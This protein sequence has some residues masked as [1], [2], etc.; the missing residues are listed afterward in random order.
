[1]PIAE[2]SLIVA[3]ISATIAFI[4]VIV[5]P[6]IS[7]KISKRQLIFPIRQKW[8]EDLR[9]VMSE[10]LSE[11]QKAIIVDE[12]QGLLS[13]KDVD[14]KL[15]GRLMYLEQKLRLILNPID[16]DHIELMK[17]VREITDAVHHGSRNLIDFGTNVGC[18]AEAT[19][20]IMRDEW[21]RIKNS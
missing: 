9:E 10:I 21:S 15:L 18:A 6:I 19:Q 2:P 13:K 14:E 8:I 4:S 11:C 17:H 12:G 16:N 20:K 7:L 5:G 3:C 1:M